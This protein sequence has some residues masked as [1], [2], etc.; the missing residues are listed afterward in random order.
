MRREIVYLILVIIYLISCKPNLIKQNNQ[1]LECLIDTYKSVFATKTGTELS[2]FESHGWTDTTIH[3]S[4]STIKSTRLSS[5]KYF[6]SEYNGVKLFLSQGRLHRDSNVLKLELL[7]NEKMII[8]NNLKWKTIELSNLEEE[9]FPPEEFDEVQIVYNIIKK[10]VEEPK[11]IA[12]DEF[13]VLLK[14]RCDLCK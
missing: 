3:L 6:Y 12:L 2:L 10:C 13:N 1:D 7:T 14:S 9:F 4:I 5:G 11:M 8:P